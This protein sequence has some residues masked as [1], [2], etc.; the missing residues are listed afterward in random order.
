[1]MEQYWM[2]KLCDMKL[3]N[4]KEIEKKSQ[5]IQQMEK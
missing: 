2:D 1:M 3:L 4:E 5:Q